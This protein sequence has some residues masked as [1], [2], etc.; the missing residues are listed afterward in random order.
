M[1]PLHIGD[2]LD[3]YRIE[4]VAARS[5]MASIF[6]AIDTRSGRQVA[7][8]VPHA[9]LESDPQF[10]DRFQRE[11]EIG[12]QMDH[13]GITKVLNGDSQS[14]VYMVME[15]AE[16]RLLRNELGENRKMSPE[17]A[18]RIALQICDALDYVHSRGVVHRDLKPENIMLAADD[19]IKLIDFGIA[20][21]AGARRLTFGNLAQLMGTPDYISPEQVEGKSGDERSDL[22]ALGTI[23]YEMVTGR[24]PFRGDTPLAAM[25]ARLISNPIPPRELASGV[26]P[27][28]QETIYRALERDPRK[29]YATARVFARDLEHPELIA[30][31]DRSEMREWAWPHKPW[32]ERVLFGLKMAAIP[33]AIF[34]LLIYVARHT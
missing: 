31:A 15:W 3:D 25:N 7:I 17:R 24:T 20:A 23:L 9:E 26:S 2:R 27:A 34:S 1:S 32:A 22:Y 13:P 12:R 33:G 4:G 29:R 19:R 6:R 18:V 11:A 21:K 10:F 30:V 28:L 8:K 16:G 5:G 14:R